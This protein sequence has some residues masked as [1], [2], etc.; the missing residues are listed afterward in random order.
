MHD[1]GG[2]SPSVK[3]CH[4][5]EIDAMIT[6]P[7]QSFLRV[8]LLLPIFLMGAYV[9]PAVGEEGGD[10]IASPAF[11]AD[12]YEVLIT[13]SPFMRLLNAA[14]SYV[15]TSV[16]NIDGESLVTVVNTVTRDRFTLSGVNNSHGWRLIELHS[17]PEPRNI[18]ARISVNGEELSVRFSENQL[19]AEALAKGAQGSGQRSQGGDSRVKRPPAGPAKDKPKNSKRDSKPRNK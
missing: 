12:R 8:L 9:C 17:D 11:S 16:T 7:A 5:Y 10:G 3:Y 6:L 18:V 4:R 13:D 19:S 2:A 14:E 15:L 1:A